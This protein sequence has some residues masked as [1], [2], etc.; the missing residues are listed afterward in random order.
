MLV[1]VFFV[2][3]LCAALFGGIF[4]WKHYVAGQSAAAQ[5]GGPPPA[6]IAATEV[7]RETWQPSLK[8]VG[9]LSAVAG[10]EVTSEVNGKI[11]TIHFR[12]GEAVDEGKLLLELDDDTDQAELRGLV[13]ERT[14]ARLRYDR[15]A[16]LV[17]EKSISKSDFDEARATLDAA[18]ARVAA[19]QA[20]IDKKRI[21][22]P[23]A[24]R[25][26]IRRIDVGQYLTAGSAIVPLEQLDPIFVDFTLP[27]RELA[28]I[29]EGQA[30]RVGVQAYPETTF[31]GTVQSID[32]RVTVANRSVRVRGLISNTGEQLRPGMFA[33]VE[34]LL[35]DRND[36]LTVPDTAI[37]YAPY[38]DSV[39]VI[40]ESD[41]GKTVNR[42]Q[43]ETGETRDGRVA[44]LSGL[45]AGERVVSAGHN[46]LRNGQAVKIDDQ[47]APGERQTP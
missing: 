14:I 2:V 34:V 1:R 15:L 4:G 7:A 13:A 10:I 33:D 18:S 12:S 20:L 22:A 41:G 35:P 40:A 5:A 11:E 8:A 31:D 26:G 36:V 25:L 6:V 43:V 29:R 42:R 3:V 45:D 38:G 44:V 21:R 23:F 39:F 46:K 28:R 16:K 32:P 47:P 19:Q 27:E 17:A 37:S 30:L 24:G 9:S